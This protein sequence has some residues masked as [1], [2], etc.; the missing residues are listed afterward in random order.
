MGRILITSGAKSEEQMG[1]SRA[2]M[3]GGW[4]FVSGT[5]GYDY[6][7]QSIAED[8]ADQT[9]QAMK[10]IDAALKQGESSLSDVVRVTCIVA[11]VDD[12]NR[13]WTVVRKYLGE[14]RPAATLFAAAL[15]DPRMK[16]EIEVTAR[17]QPP[18]QDRGT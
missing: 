6:S 12:A 2:V 10:N 13:C 4:I 18:S 9:E 14:V 16:V 3:D 7:T 1:F 15:A 8:A 5:G 11:N 17:R